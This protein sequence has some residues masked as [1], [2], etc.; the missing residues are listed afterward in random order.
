MRAR[1]AAGGTTLPWPARGQTEFLQRLAVE[2]VDDRVGLADE[3]EEGGP[4][5]IG[6]V[7][8]AVVLHVIGQLVEPVAAIVDV[9]LQLFGIGRAPP[10]RLAVGTA[11]AGERAE[12]RRAFVVHDVI[13]IAARIAR[14]AVGAGHAW[15]AEPR[16]EVEQNLLEGTHVA[17]GLHHRLADR[18][19]RAIGLRDRAVEQRDAV[20]ALEIGGVRQDQ[21]GVVRPSR[22]HRH[23]SR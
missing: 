6:P 15:K 12:P 21:V 13:G 2:L 23:R 10:L 7:H 11:E 14:A 22:T 3:A 5:E 20:P 1:C 4:V 9:M 18:I 17:I 8:M 16:A 19:G